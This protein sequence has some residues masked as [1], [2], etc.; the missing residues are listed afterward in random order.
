MSGT[1]PESG[2]RY[3]ASFVLEHALWIWIVVLVCAAF[4]VAVRKR[5]NITSRKQ[6]LL[7]KDLIS[8]WGGA[9]AIIAHV[10][11]YTYIVGGDHFEYRVY[12]HLIVP[13]LLSFI[14]ALNY[15]KIRQSLLV[16]FLIGFILVSAI[17]PWTHWSVSKNIRTRNETHQLRV[18]I[19]DCF[20]EYLGFYVRYF[21]DL[22][23]WL[24]S[25][26][27][28]S[29]HQEHKIANEEWMSSTLPTREEGSKISADK[30][31]VM[32]FWGGI[33]GLGWVLP[34]VY[35]IDLFGLNDYVIA[36]SK[37]PERAAKK[38][39]HERRPPKGYVECFL[40]NVNLGPERT[41]SIAKRPLKLT[42][43][44]II[45]S[46]KKWRNR[47]KESGR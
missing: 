33:G 26:Y 36:R 3:L 31:P 30:N 41:V 4:A 17:I 9:A 34:H 16:F 38:M 39:A 42:E 27:V 35:F 6:P 22:Q 43:E 12:S 10:C 20:P 7:I 19:A 5:K 23:D 1:W 11:Y 28:C 21:D 15:L 2:I 32:A 45:L 47:L 40:P 29:R 8:K 46:E 44:K 14:W 24:I 18:K 25:H 37:N 13:L